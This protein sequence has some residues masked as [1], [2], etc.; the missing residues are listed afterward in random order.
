MS[1][2]E[3]L[4]QVRA[5]RPVLEAGISS[6]RDPLAEQRR[7]RAELAARGRAVW[8]Y[9]AL[10]NEHVWAGTQNS[11]G[12]VVYSFDPWFD[13]WPGELRPVALRLGGFY[14]SDRAVEDP[15][16]RVVQDRTRDG[17]GRIFGARLPDAMTGGRV[18]FES[19]TWFCL[20]DLPGGRLLDHV[21]PMWVDDD[22]YA[23]VA[24][25]AAWPDELRATWERASIQ[26][27]S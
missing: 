25:A 4:D 2:K 10:A 1:H 12:A 23:M 26:P 7:R 5:R 15:A 6:S 9:V 20:T 16:L 8:G 19:S 24:V 22:G 27:S 3:L 14:A 21:V 11:P 13:R 18:V 17:H